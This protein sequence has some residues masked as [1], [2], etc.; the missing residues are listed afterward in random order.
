MLF[1]DFFIPTREPP[2]DA[3]SLIVG[4]LHRF[5]INYNLIFYGRT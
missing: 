5:Y 3:R 1:D 4:R 2:F